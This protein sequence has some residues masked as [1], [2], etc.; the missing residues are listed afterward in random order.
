METP[1]VSLPDLFPATRTAVLI[2]S[3][4]E[5]A[6]RVVILDFQGTLTPLPD[7]VAFVQALQAQGDF[8]I[9]WSGSPTS[10]IED[11]VPGLLDAVDFFLGKPASLLDA[12]KA[13]PQP[14]TEVVVVDD[15][16]YIG[17][18]ATR[19]GRTRPEEWRYVPAADILRLQGL[20]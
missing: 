5:V 19:Y 14:P 8:V 15:Q 1:L 16:E 12:V 17:Y 11:R 6:M 2:D 18:A 9:L 10:H 4:V 13:C 3:P 7:P 20:N